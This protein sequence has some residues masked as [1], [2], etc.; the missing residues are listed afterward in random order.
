MGCI[1]VNAA[2]VREAIMEQ[3]RILRIDPGAFGVSTGFGVCN[4][5]WH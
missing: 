4:S 3:G 2:A 1:V 5:M